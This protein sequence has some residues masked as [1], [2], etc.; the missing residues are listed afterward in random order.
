MKSAMWPLLASV[1]LA[2]CL[3]NAAT[4]CSDGTVCPLDR[5]CVV[6]G[7]A[8][9]EQLAAC[10]SL[11]DG[12]AC[13]FA[14]TA[15]QCL[16]GQCI[17]SLCGN[18]MLD[19]LEA[20]DDGNV[21]SGDG[22]RADCAKIEVCG[23]AI[24]DEGEACDDGDDNPANGCDAC[25]PTAW[26][27]TAIIG[28]NANASTVALRSPRQLVRDLEGNLYVA[29]TGHH[30]VRRIDTNGVVTVVAGSGVA[31]YSGD[32]GVATN[33]ELSAPEAIAVDGV[34]NVFIA[35]TGNARVRRV[36]RT[37]VITTV[38]GTGDLLGAVGDGGPATAAGVGSVRGL[39]VDGLGN[40]YL[41]DAI[42]ERVRRVDAAGIITTVAGNGGGFAGDNGPATSALFN[43]VGAIALD[44]TGRLFIA[45]TGNNRIR[46]VE[47]GIIKTYAGSSSCSGTG[48]CL[49]GFGGDGS[50]A[51]TALLDHPAALVVTATAV[52]VADTSN[53]RIRRIDATTKT[54]TTIAGSASVG[55]AGDGGA[56][57]AASLNDPSGLAIDASGVIYLSDTDNNRIRSVSPGGI[58]TTIAGTTLDEPTGDGGSATSAILGDPVGVAVDASG[59]V[60]IADNTHH[61]IRRVTPDG[62]ISTV[63]GTGDAGYRASDE[64]K[65]AVNA[66]LNGPKFVMLDAAGNL[67]ITDTLNHRVRKVD[68]AGNITTIA[69]SGAAGYDGDGAQATTKSLNYPIALAFDASGNLLIADTQNNRVRKVDG[70][71]IITTIAGTGV[72]GFGG[73]N[74]AATGAKLAWPWALAVR[75]AEIFI[76][77]MLNQ[78]I[79]RID[80]TG[81]I[82]T[83]A[84]TGTAGFNGDNISATSAQIYNPRGLAFDASGQLLIA[85]SA[86]NR[87]R[88][89]DLAGKI[90][91]IAGT[92]ADTTSGDG[93]LATLAQ[94]GDPYAIALDSSG[95]IYTA[96]SLHKRVRRID[97]AGIIRTIAGR[98]DPAGMGP[99]SL[100]R[101]ADPQSY[102]VTPAFGLVGGG[103]SGTIQL[104]RAGE[105][106]VG[107]GRYAQ[108]TSTGVLARYRNTLAGA[109]PG[110]GSVG[111]AAYDATA[112]VI[113]LTETS[114][115]RIHTITIVDPDDPSTWTIAPLANSAG[116]F[117]H[118]DGAAA[119]ARFRGPTGLYLD[120]VAR[121]LYVADT[122]NHVIRKIDLATATVSTP[123]GTPATRG[124]FGDGGAATG[125]LLFAPRALTRCTNGDLFIADTGNNRV[126]RV[127]AGSNVITTVLGDGV[128]ASSGEGA[129]AAIFPVNAPHELACDDLGNVLVT[130]TTTVR[131]LPADDAGTVDG[132]GAVQT[133]YGAAPRTEFPA[134]VTSCLSGIAVID[135]ATV[136]VTDS[137]TGILVELKRAPR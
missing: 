104:V 58:I 97:A 120:T 88:R 44:A 57:L 91:T 96:S 79:R 116:T 80:A 21:S 18:G 99:R 59:N 74:Q 42:N 22:C 118:L 16:G 45:D 37:G 135:P 98:V 9:P 110:F 56:A 73:D 47:N 46:V 26:T 39:A 123:I 77:D 6:G 49:G 13:T 66:W 27:A 117:G 65:P 25:V 35:D 85:D 63:A 54:I 36:D 78:R 48:F 105:V 95:R 75:G 113:Y 64:G 131:M 133:I 68:T 2:A 70:T 33:A 119:T 114:A 86:N 1:M 12:A 71:G 100:A 101:L 15:G 94:L 87:L 128:A 127:A 124:F 81:K 76:G 51:T 28:G 31:G 84:G 14:G 60:Y 40:L 109:V 112:N 10:E 61:Q 34:G 67:Y 4:I 130:S 5:V 90:T 137:C 43:E 41:S 115:N 69:G 107:G 83:F 129:P 23:D 50:S 32:G 29:D 53:Q 125:G 38:A 106:E 82:S 132:G 17:G 62:L 30:Q 102:V 126:R 122:G 93:A 55:F 20:C 136:H 3:E 7:C 24:L 72:Q 134:R 19:A 11:E 52:F 121:Q 111:G 89:I 92:G 103:D 8:L 108:E